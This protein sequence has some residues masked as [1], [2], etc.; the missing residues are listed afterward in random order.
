M[1][2]GQGPL[3]L[4]AANSH[5]WFPDHDNLDICQQDRAGNR[6]PRCK[7]EKRTDPVLAGIMEIQIDIPLRNEIQIARIVNLLEVRNKRC[8]YQTSA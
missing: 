5:S 6:F 8:M 2:G 7:I 1:L 3:Y 4:L